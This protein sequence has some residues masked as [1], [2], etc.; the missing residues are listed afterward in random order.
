MVR[1]RSH[2]DLGYESVKV[3]LKKTRVPELP[4]GEISMILRSLVL[5][6]YQRVTDRRTDTPPIAKTNSGIAERDKPV[7]LCEYN[8]VQRKASVRLLCV[9]NI[10]KTTDVIRCPF[11]QYAAKMLK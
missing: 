6:Q 3:G 5:T 7:A 9:W 1:V 8:L 2:C 10:K 4:A 11:L